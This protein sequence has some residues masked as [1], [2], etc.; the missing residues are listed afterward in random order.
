MNGSATLSGRTGARTTFV[1]IHEIG[2]SEAGAV[3]KTMEKAVMA[4]F[5]RRPR[6]S[7]R[8]CAC[9]CDCRHQG[10]LG[11]EELVTQDRYS[12]GPAWP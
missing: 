2:T 4:T 9:A 3:V 10:L 5:R 6:R 1:S 12:E 7:T 11:K 8:R